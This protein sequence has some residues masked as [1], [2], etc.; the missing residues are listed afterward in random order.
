MHI[1]YIN[2]NN[3][4]TY[5]LLQFLQKEENQFLTGNGYNTCRILTAICNSIIIKDIKKSKLARYLFLGKL[6]CK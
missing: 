1:N 5:K 6:K 2:K 3:V 4:D